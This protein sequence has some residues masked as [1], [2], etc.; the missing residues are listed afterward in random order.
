MPL[1]AHIILLAVYTYDCRSLIAVFIY[2]FA[3]NSCF[4][5]MSSRC[6]K[7]RIYKKKQKTSL[8]I[9]S[10]TNGKRE[11]IQVFLKSKSVLRSIDIHTHTSIF[12]NISLINISSTFI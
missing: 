10:L 7:N 3:Y 12:N 8:C 11:K 2:G 4:A 9:F 5:I 6:N 1:S